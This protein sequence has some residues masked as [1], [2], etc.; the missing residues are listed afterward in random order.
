MLNVMP[1][2]MPA[3]VRDLTHLFEKK[4]WKRRAKEVFA[5]RVIDL[6]HIIYQTDRPRVSPLPEVMCNSPDHRNPVDVSKQHGGKKCLYA[7]AAPLKLVIIPEFHAV[8]KS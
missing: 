5:L 7:C 4:L 2:F 1:V 3:T 8:R 6:S